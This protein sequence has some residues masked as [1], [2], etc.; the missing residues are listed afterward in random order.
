MGIFSVPI[1]IKSSP[2]APA[3][4]SVQ[5]VVDTGAYISVVPREILE[6]LG[7]K[8]HWRR[9]FQLADG[10]VIEREVGGATFVW[11]G[12][13]GIAEVVFGEKTDKP[14]LG[15]ITLESMALKVNMQKQVLESLDTL[16]LL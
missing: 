2:D 11:D 4:E 1:I 16:L 14:L 13:E 10:S 15:A 6:R 9:K 7:V 3:K 5:M 8:P 12:Q